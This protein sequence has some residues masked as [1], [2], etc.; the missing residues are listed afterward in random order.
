[1]STSPVAVFFPPPSALTEAAVLP[2]WEQLPRTN[3]QRLIS[4]L[5]RLVS[6]KLEGRS[7]T[8]GGDERP[9]LGN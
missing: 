6:R 7:R 3:R 4:V 8:E 9:D 1:M 5:T 2:F